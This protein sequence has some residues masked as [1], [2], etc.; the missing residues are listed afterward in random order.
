MQTATYD[1]IITKHNI[2][3]YEIQKLFSHAFD[4][5]YVLSEVTIS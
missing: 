3:Y 4:L 5:L 1:T 2:N